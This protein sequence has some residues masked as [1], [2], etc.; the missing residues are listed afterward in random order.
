MIL[1]CLPLYV[2]FTSPCTFLTH[3]HAEQAARMW[4]VTYTVLLI[5][6]H[7]VST[8]DV[9]DLAGKPHFIIDTVHSHKTIVTC[10]NG[11][12]RLFHQLHDIRSTYR[13]EVNEQYCTCYVAHPVSS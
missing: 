11:E 12:V 10:V 8:P 3:N 5:H 13:V 6:F 9:V 2:L 4:L 7:L 1:N